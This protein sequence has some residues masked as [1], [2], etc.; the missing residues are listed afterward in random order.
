M[1]VFIS[2]SGENSMSHKIALA[3]HEWFPCVINYLEPFVSSE[4]IQKGERGLDK[5]EELL[6]ESDYGIISV[7]KENYK[8]PWLLFEA[9][10]L[11][12]SPNKI[13]VSPFLFDLKPS[14]LTGNPLTQFQAATTYSGK[15][16]IKKLIDSLNE[17]CGEKKLSDTTLEKSFEK[18]YPDLEEAFNKIRAE[19]QV[20]EDDTA[21]VVDENRVILE[22]MLAM[23]RENRKLLRNPELH[24]AEGVKQILEKLDRISNQ[25]SRNE[26]RERRRRRKFHPV[27]IEEVFHRCRKEIGV[28]QG[29]HIALSFFKEDFPWVYELGKDLAEV[30][31]SKKSMEH[32][33]KAIHDFI[34]TLEFAPRIMRFDKGMESEEE[35]MILHEMP[36]IFSK[37]LKEMSHS[38]HFMIESM[39]D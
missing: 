15:K 12:N 18:W 28:E 39:E 20:E 25:N 16:D 10:A 37:F 8:A 3:L 17:R 21:D 19:T 26:E 29:F 38:K 9:G 4:D 6:K 32:K 31:K 14:D 13:P 34:N 35:M 5:I 22:E 23:T 24:D 7:T 27:M 2:W 36:M 33:E 11:S 30:L 1:K